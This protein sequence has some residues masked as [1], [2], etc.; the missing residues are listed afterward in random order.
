M[1]D[2]RL[3]AA[4]PVFLAETAGEADASSFLNPI[5]P[6][7][8]VAEKT[9]QLT[10]P[11]DLRQK[12]LEQGKLPLKDLQFDWKKLKLDFSWF[13]QLHK[14]DHWAF[15]YQVA[16]YGMRSDFTIENLPMPLY[17]QLNDWAKLYLLH[18]RGTGQ[19]RQGFRDVEHLARLVYT[20]EN[21][22]AAL[23]SVALLNISHK[24]YDE[25]SEKEKAGLALR[26][27][28]RAYLARAKRYFYAQTALA[29]LRLEDSTY[30]KFSHLPASLCQRANDAMCNANGLRKILIQDLPGRYERLN[31]L[32]ADTE[33]KCR[34]SFMRQ[35]WKN[36]DSSILLSRD[37]G[38]FGTTENVPAALSPK[39][40]YLELA[41]HP[42]V[43]ISVAY[44]LLSIAEPNWLKQYEN[45]LP[46]H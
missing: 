23:S 30:I 14:F 25:L 45:P 39:L 38:I 43:G 26:P 16:P 17:G 36:P 28:S 41:Q 35:V 15:D 11:A 32:V 19:L 29:D 34:K 2:A 5:I 33:P 13:S 8:G 20:N 4:D 1:E 7:D 44:L 22:L 27:R 46:E 24:F 10:L 3:L 40:T 9:E 37:K 6:W 18:A 42:S 21:M 31:K 12:L